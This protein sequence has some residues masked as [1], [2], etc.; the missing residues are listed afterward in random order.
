MSTPISRRAA[1]NRAA[2]QVPNWMPSSITARGNEDDNELV[3][4]AGVYELRTLLADT[5]VAVDELT[6]EEVFYRVGF[7][8]GVIAAKSVHARDWGE[9]L[10]AIAA[11]AKDKLQPDLSKPPPVRATIPKP[12]YQRLSPAPTLS[13]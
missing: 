7:A 5:L 11:L 13:H 9:E 3:D 1:I 6:P 8:Q 2:G 4:H 12:P 10:L